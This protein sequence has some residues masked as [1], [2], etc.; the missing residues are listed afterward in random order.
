MLFPCRLV[1]SRRTGAIFSS[2][3]VLRRFLRSTL[4]L[5]A[6][7]SAARHTAAQPPDEE[8]PR[9]AAESTPRSSEPRFPAYSLNSLKAD[10]RVVDGEL[11][12]DVRLKALVA[13][14][15][16]VTIPLRL[17]E[18]IL[19]EE[20]Q[21]EGG[22]QQ[23]LRVD[24]EGGG[25]TWSIRAAKGECQVRIRCRIKL[26]AI[27]G[28]TALRVTAPSATFSELKFT[29]PGEQV[30]GVELRTDVD[31]AQFANGQ[32]TFALRG[33]DGTA[34][35]TWKPKDELIVR[36]S[37]ELGAS[38]LVKSQFDGLRRL[39]TSTASI[40]VRSINESTSFSEFSVR[41]P[42]SA[43]VESISPPDAQLH[44]IGTGAN[45]RSVL[46]FR[47]AETESFTAE[48]RY[49]QSLDA[50]GEQHLSLPGIEVIG[51]RQW[52][53]L[54]VKAEGPWRLDW[55]P[56][57][58]RS[59][60]RVTAGDAEGEIAAGDYDAVFE[61][62][63]AAAAVEVRSYKPEP[64]VSV[65][66]EFAFL[67][68]ADEIVCEGRLRCVA[69]GA[70]STV[71]IELRDWSEWSVTEAFIDAKPPVPLPVEENQ[72]VLSL[73]KSAATGV[74]LRF[75]AVRD[76]PRAA[77]S[78]ALELP[79]IA[80]TA[81]RARVW[82][83]PRDNVAL[84]VQEQASPGWRRTPDSTPLPSEL[85]SGNWSSPASS[86]VVSAGAM[87]PL[88]TRFEV[89]ARR[90]SVNHRT[91]VSFASAAATVL[92]IME[93]SVQND[94]L[95]ELT[96]VAPAE[97]WEL[98][99]L[100]ITRGGVDVPVTWV[101]DA[102]SG[103]PRSG[104][105]T[106]PSP[107]SPG[108]AEISCRWD[109]VQPPLAPGDSR[110]SVLG[111]V[112]PLGVETR[113]MRLTIQAPPWL[114]VQVADESWRRDVN[115]ASASAQ[116]ARYSHLGAASELRLQLTRESDLAHGTLQVEKAWIQTWLFGGERR[117]RVLYRFFSSGGQVGLVL[118]EDATWIQVRLNAATVAVQNRPG[119][120]ASLRI[121]DSARPQPYLLDLQYRV[122][123][124]SRNWL[125]LEFARLDPA[126][127]VQEGW[128][129]IIAPDHQHLLVGPEQ[130]SAEHAWQWSGAWWRRL[131][132]R[133]AAELDAWI[134]A[135]GFV[136]P[137][138]SNQ[139]AYSFFGETPRV[140]LAM[141]SRAWLVG[142]ASAVTLAIGLLLAYVPALRQRGLLLVS[143]VGLLAAALMF[144]SP[145][146]LIAQA[147]SLGFVLAIVAAALRGAFVRRPKPPAANKT[148]GS[149]M[150]YEFGSTQPGQPVPLISR[151]RGSTLT[152]VA[153]APATEK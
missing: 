68:G 7:V 97:A 115:G 91:E 29:V 94:N 14:E 53:H 54:A 16:P 77:D 140:E 130:L 144:P 50:N 147:A 84:D 19:L 60:D 135:E 109:V 9:D 35:F 52:G 139:Y 153:S 17:D 2:N 55:R 120:A 87:R 31:P 118:P 104:K 6:F 41:M 116:A 74:S 89:H 71:R 83:Q 141:A 25:L 107:L 43:V 85:L 111:L 10:G 145:A 96:F 42:S 124:S 58:A 15:E 100:Q 93:L 66:P 123:G 72:I 49:H 98:S 8:R 69:S 33:L 65:E 34:T 126:A 88:V 103:R 70:A 149:S 138:G 63:S 45:V 40:R 48:V 27:D 26:G 32:T 3:F 75:R 23:S 148:A 110:L 64:R 151:P 125:D 121:P 5:A 132:S 142:L 11:E 101:S 134:G 90:V 108:T 105:L 112:E 128:L 102:A 78:L 119:G 24:S 20:P 152:G 95:T 21:F 13:G 12:L 44:T 81:R 61:L 36:G 76:T 28:E 99:T 82:V 67:V 117:D 92:Q 18:C 113:S 86:Y 62:Y 79:V 47:H 51:A 122:T 137:T 59:V 150:R 30:A 1:R 106:F 127:W 146:I 57:D 56:L 133:G 143:A 4:L 136:P 131:P 37:P 73:E 38:L 39:L 22:G 80:P 129:Q 46:L 114:L